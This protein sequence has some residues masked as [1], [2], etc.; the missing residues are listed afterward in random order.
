MEKLKKIA[1]IDQV[2]LT[3][4]IVDL[5]EQHEKV[6]LDFEIAARIVL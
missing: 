5:I 6:S 1:L 3:I 4:D 2:V